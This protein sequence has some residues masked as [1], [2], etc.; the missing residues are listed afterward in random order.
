M[1]DESFDVIITDQEYKQLKLQRQTNVELT[2]KLTNIQAKLDK[3][4]AL[5]Q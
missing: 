3:S 5:E 2:L 4:E 1:A